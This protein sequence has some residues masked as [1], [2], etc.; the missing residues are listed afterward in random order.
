MDGE[1]AAGWGGQAPSNPN[2]P[3]A[4]FLSL[5]ARAHPASRMPAPKSQG[6]GRAVPAWPLPGLTDCAPLELSGGLRGI[7]S[8]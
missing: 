7:C 2:P 4:V 6:K 1:D 5:P 8:V 3:R